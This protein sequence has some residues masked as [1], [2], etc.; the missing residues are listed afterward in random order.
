MIARILLVSYFNDFY[1]TEKINEAKILAQTYATSLESN[2]DAKALITEQL[3]TKL[4]VAGIIASQQEQP[5]SNEK[6]KDLAETLGIDAFYIYG[7]DKKI[8]YTSDGLHLGWVASKGH[9]VMDFYESGRNHAIDEVRASSET[10]TYWLF[11]Y[12]RIEGERMIQS[13]I[14][15]DKL[16]KLYKK[17]N[18]QWIIDQIVKESPLIQIAYI[19]QE[20]VITASSISEEIGQVVGKREL[21][22]EPDDSHSNISLEDLKLDWHLK[23]YIPIHVEN[24]QVGTLSFMFDLTN[25]NRL[26]SQISITVTIALIL[27]FILFSFIIINIAKHNK[28]IFTIAYFDEVTG[29]PN[30][31]FLKQ[32]L[33]DQEQ[34]DLALIIINPLHLKF[35]NLIYGYHYGDTILYQMGKNLESL[36]FKGIPIQAYRFTNDQFILTV[37]N[38]GSEKMLYTICQKILSINDISEALSSLNL[39]IGVVEWKKDTLDFTMLIKQASIALNTA[40]ETNRIQF[41]TNEMEQLI[42]RKDAIETELKRIVAGEKDILYL[43]YQP[44]VKAKDNSIVSFEALARMQSKTLG[45]VPPKEFIAIAEERHLIIPLGKIILEQ[46]ATFMKHLKDMGYGMY[47]IGVNVSAMQ[48]LDEA[49]VTALQETIQKVEIEAEQLVI[50]LTESAFS[51]NFE[52]LSQQVKNIHILGIR[53]A[54]DD[55]GIG[56]SSLNRL[57]GLYVDILKLDKQFV[58]RLTDPLDE[59]ISSD[60]ISMGHHL[61][62]QIIAEGVEMEEQRQHLLSMDCDF[63]QGYLFSRPVGEKEVLRLLEKEQDGS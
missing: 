23:F 51:H 48:L 5:F 50:E 29:L 25:T 2:L 52:F 62:K 34:K 61:G 4:Q 17:L 8:K 58:D 46:A 21:S 39:T 42:Q 60:I 26:F 59:G 43:A 54:I 7:P 49:F 9:P 24:E 63:L 56:F 36:P 12:Q 27:L 1:H 18:E 11:S 32:V 37:K 33:E 6:F 19:N 20:N 13:G 28:R 55:F 45:S 14:L 47:S 57:E 40:S 16:V 3:H 38:Y 15:A 41:Y 30:I 53:V 22:E 35:I 10:G 44:I 31:R